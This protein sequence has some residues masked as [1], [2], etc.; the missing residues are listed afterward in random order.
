VGLDERS[1][2]NRIVGHNLSTFSHLAIDFPD[3]PRRQK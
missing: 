3:F 1:L 2:S